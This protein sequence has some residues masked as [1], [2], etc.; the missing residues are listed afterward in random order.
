MEGEI[1]KFGFSIILLIIVSVHVPKH[2][3]E[4]EKNLTNKISI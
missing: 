3:R 2:V 1:S 4:Y